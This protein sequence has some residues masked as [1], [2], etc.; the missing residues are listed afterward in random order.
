MKDLQGIGRGMLPGEGGGRNGPLPAT[1]MSL[2]MGKAETNDYGLVSG[3]SVAAS[4]L[5]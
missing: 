2:R 3:E 4:G 1:F 5:G